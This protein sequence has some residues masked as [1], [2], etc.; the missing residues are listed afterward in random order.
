MMMLFVR[1]YE[2]DQHSPRNEFVFAV[3][4]PA[5]HMNWET[6]SACMFTCQLFWLQFMWQ[7][8]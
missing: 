8:L 2:L 6:S 5:L 7:K 1:L 4:V 3:N